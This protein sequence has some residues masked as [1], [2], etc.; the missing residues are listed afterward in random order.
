MSISPPTQRDIIVQVS[1]WEATGDEGAT[2]PLRSTSLLDRP[3]D[4]GKGWA[5]DKSAVSDFDDS[6]AGAAIPGSTEH[7][8]IGILTSRF[9]STLVETRYVSPTKRWEGIQKELRRLESRTSWIAGLQD[10][11]D[12]CGTPAYDKRTIRA[13]LSFVEEL[14][15]LA[16]DA[17]ENRF[18]MPRLSPGIDGAIDIYWEELGKPY[19]VV[20]VSAI[21]ENI[22]AYFFQ[23][24]GDNAWLK[25]EFPHSSRSRERALRSLLPWI[26]P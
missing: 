25:A 23:R 19:L 9:L 8:G 13:A 24:L 1:E 12:D 5:G 10:D 16:V 6:I 15:R 17:G 3:A 14:A 18:P 4:P 26:I 2:V 22:I 7:S 11:W 21:S 20:R